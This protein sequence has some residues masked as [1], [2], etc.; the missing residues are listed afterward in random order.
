MYDWM[1]D[2]GLHQAELVVYAAIFDILRHEPHKPQRINFRE[3]ADRIKYSCASV[4]YSVDM[5]VEHGF[6]YSKGVRQDRIVSLY[7]I[8]N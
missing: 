4:I 6:L 7:P 8:N 2:A 1:F 5:L 3:L